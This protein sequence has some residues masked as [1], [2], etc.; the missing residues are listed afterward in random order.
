MD[1]GKQMAEPF[2]GEL[3]C[4]G[5]NF[6]P[7]GYLNCDGQELPISQNVALFSLF[8]TMYGGDG[9]TT[10]GLPALRGRTPIHVGQ[11]PGL[12]D[13]K[14]GSSGGETTHALTVA[15]LGA[16]TH[17]LVNTTDRT[18]DNG[19]VHVS[20][21]GVK[22]VSNVQDPNTTA[23]A[24]EQ[25]YIRANPDVKLHGAAAEIRGETGKT[26]KSVEVDAHNNLMPYLT[27]RWIVAS[28]GIYP[29]RS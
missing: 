22:E 1:K 27:L 5:F 26:G 20:M 10:F 14:Q 18:P 8:G 21:H 15:E 17:S 16:H 24:K 9:R 23:L 7:R 3:M 2:I 28:T 12:T 6:A 4:V 13:R 29:S 19:L 25:S 11:G